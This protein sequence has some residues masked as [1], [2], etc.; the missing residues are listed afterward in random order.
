MKNT[1]FLLAILLLPACGGSSSNPGSDTDAAVPEPDAASGETGVPTLGGSDA[2][3][4]APGCR[5]ATALCAKLDQCAPFLLKATYGDATKCADRLTTVCTAQSLSSGSG[6]TEAN[7][8]ACEASL[9]TATCDDVFANNLP[10]CA[11]HGTLA[12]GAT[13][14]DGSQCASGFCS[15]GGNLCGVCAA[16]G[17]A[18]AAC[19]SGS[20]DECQTGLVCTSGKICAQPAA[21][22]AACDDT[23]KPCL[24]GSFCTIAKT[25]ALTVA[26]GQSCPGAYLNVGDGTICLGQTSAQIGT[27]SAG[28]PCG[29]APSNGAP[30]TLCAPGGVPACTLLSGGIQLFGLPTK[31]ICAAPIDNGYTCT[32]TDI[33]QPGA[34]CIAGTCQI[35]S[36]RYCQQDAGT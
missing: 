36:G 6:M 7:I 29:L 22:G 4:V 13:C 15:H 33:C 25:C 11:F 8:L 30:A 3:A 17:A 32:A 26:V 35:P 27:A 19:A 24:I 1:P 9:A 34:L 28:Q 5:H 20:N 31:G 23:T 12:D 14:G 16:K 2:N 18:G 10:A 21:V